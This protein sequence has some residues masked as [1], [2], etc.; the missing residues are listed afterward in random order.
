MKQES[1]FDSFLTEEG[2]LFGLVLLSLLGA[3]FLV[4]IIIYL[5]VYGRLRHYR[6]PAGD[7]KVAQTGVSVVIPLYDAD[8][9]F[10]NERLPQFL[11][12]THSLY[13]VMI[14]DVTGDPDIAEQL[15]LMHLGW[16]DKLAY[17]RISL[18]SKI[19]H[20]S[21]K[22]AL[23]V[24]IKGAR[25]DNVVFSLPECAPR[26]ERWAEMMARG[27][28]GGHDVVLGYA[29]IVP[30]KGLAN[31]IV[32]C[33]NMALSTRWLSF[34]VRNRGYRGTLC[35]IGITK[36]VY[37]GARGF[38]YLNLNM[39]EDDL[40][41]MNLINRTNTVT[42]MG[43]SATINQ[44]CWGGLGGWL[45]RRLK[46]SYTYRY[47][48]RRVKW[49]TG[50]ELWSRALFF[51]AAVVAMAMLPLASKVLAA[52]LLFARYFIVWWQMKT[53]ARRL[54]ERGFLS[55]YWIYDLLAPAVEAVLFVRREL[56]PAHKWR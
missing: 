34:A 11:S 52:V 8:Y 13:E 5:F 33:A 32:R 45:P 51:V 22:M 27:F 1:F 25:Y 7:D 21:T 28:A 2:R 16:G 19:R 12:Q 39:G 38:N 26:T 43:G 35:N 54:S 10:M 18:N 29:S 37:F 6:N 40:F 42:T 3:M 20:I 4:Q 17:T 15:K 23:N 49:G 44:Q 50:I 31:K 56:T 46:L 24:G 14:V 48:P 53:V 30:E 55:A 41:V 36:S 47:Y 9:G